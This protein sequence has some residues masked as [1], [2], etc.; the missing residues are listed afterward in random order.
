M[1]LEE[2]AAQ[3]RC[4]WFEKGKILDARTSAFSPEKAA[5]EMPHGIGQIGRPSDTAGTPR[6][7]ASAFREPADAIRFINDAQRYAIERTRLGIPLLFHEEAAH[8]LAVKGATSFPIP[9]ALGSTWDPALMEHVFTYV[10]R[11][12]RARGATVVLAPVLDL[13]RDPRWG[14]SEEFYGEDPYLVGQFGTAAVRG[15]QGPTRPIAADRVFATL[16]HFIH[17]TPL[18]GVNIG[19]SDMS[20]R[21]L[22]ASFLPPFAK[23]IREGHAAIIMPSYNEVGGVPSH[24]NEHLLQEIGRKLLGFEGAYFS[25]YGGVEEISGLHHMGRDKD[26]AAVLAMRAGVDA[27]LPEGDAYRNL[28]ALVQAGRIP[29]E[30]VDAAVGRILALKFEAGLF[31]HPYVDERRAARVLADPAG[32]AL[33]R[34]VAQRAIVLLKNDGVLPL[35][36]NRA[37][38]LA[39]IGPNSVD[40]HLGGYAGLPD[41]AVGVLE[42]I[43]AATG[44]RIT[45]EQ[46]DGT[47]ITQRD[48]RGRPLAGQQVHRV[49]EGGND[50]RIGEAAALAARSDVVLLVV[51]DNEEVTRETTSAFAPGDRNS[52]SLFGDQDKLVDAVLAAGK[53]VVALLLNG[54]P[55][56]VTKLADKANALLE[57]WYL[58]EQGGNA[59]A[60]VLFGK[61]NPG[62]KLTVS[63]PRTV[64][65]FPV[66]YDR[67]PSSF[68]NPYIEGKIEPLF[69]FGYGL[70]YTTFEVSAPRL[71]ASSIAV[72]ETARVEVDVAN[73]GRIA[74]DEV[75]QLYIRDDVSSVPRPVL[76]LRG[77]QRVGL[78]PGERKTVAFELA[79]D[80]LAFWDIAMRFVV[81]PGTFTISAG[82]S[83]A[84]L[85]SISLTVA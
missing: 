30:A 68:K 57:G 61:I 55:L 27:N 54:R 8:G 56:A 36:P 46:A 50:A 12:A 52:I 71:A 82:S 23:A 19:P 35:D 45:I 70:S 73:T 65:D 75:V 67:Q 72:G 32:P 59:V 85:K 48:D 69:P 49:P 9:P 3:L 84:S 77:F 22:R 21:M 80:D 2:K 81:E 20:E 11:Q 83:S 16:K 26:D 62:G 25:D 78:K 7:T 15:L 1:T 47:W 42:G 34:A 74:G 6:F 39:V 40:A 43:K 29:I 24:A 53:P 44:G 41:R 14:R 33:A 60:D 31:E 38:K 64:G 76:E 10:S 28:P 4:I 17:G 66:Y 13:L 37:M 58:G 51:G 79:P 63:M 5:V 18:N